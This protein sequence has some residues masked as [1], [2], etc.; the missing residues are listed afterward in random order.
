MWLKD[1]SQSFPSVLILSLLN[2]LPHL[3]RRGLVRHKTRTMFL[4]LLGQDDNRSWIKYA[5]AVLLKRFIIMNYIVAFPVCD[6]FHLVLKLP[7]VFKLSSSKPLRFPF[8]GCDK[9]VV[10]A[11]YFTAYSSYSI[12]VVLVVLVFHII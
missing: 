5:I 7:P 9:T 11:F 4:G 2:S 12:S 1:I 8:H 10:A 6:G 3:M